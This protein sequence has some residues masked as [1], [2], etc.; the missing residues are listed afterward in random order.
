MRRII[1]LAALLAA[2][3][4]L[5]SGCM[6][7]PGMTV[8]TDPNAT[9][10]PTVE[11]L[12]APVF[13][14]REAVYEWYNQ[15]NLGDTLEDLTARFGE[16]VVEKSNNGTNYIWKNEA[17]YGF[18]AVFFED[19]NK[20]RAKV[21]Y[22]DDMRQ[23]KGLSGAT[24]IAGFATLKKDSDFTMTCMTLGGK[25]CELALIAL[26]SSN[27]PDTQHLYIWLDEK[28]SSIQVLFDSDEKVLQVSYALDDSTAE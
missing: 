28:G 9:A 10:A 12:T 5:L 19:N 23:L 6:G 21:I 25:P 22:Y 7:L 2:V 3:T 26:D 4:L 15:V 18:A 13:T 17:G 27:N 8:Q 11:P 24:N 20:L 1:K 14:D 16:P